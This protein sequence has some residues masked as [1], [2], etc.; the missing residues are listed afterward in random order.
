MPKHNWYAFVL[1]QQDI[2]H[3]YQTLRDGA[4]TMFP[5]FRISGTDM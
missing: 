3:Q 5:D 2:F 1:Q 4:D